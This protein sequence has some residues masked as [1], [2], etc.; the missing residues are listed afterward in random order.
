MKKDDFKHIFTA[1][2]PDPPH[3][4]DWFFAE[5]V[6]DDDCI[7]IG[8]DAKGHA[9]TCLLAQPYTFRYCGAEL[10]SAYISCVATLP[11]SRS[12]G[13]SSALLG[14]AL[15]DLRTKGY[16]LAELIPA[17]DSLYFYYSRFGFATAFYTD[18]LRYTALHSFPK[19]GTEVPPDY[20][21]FHA[22]EM[23][24]PDGVLHSPG[25]Y[26]RILADLAL[27]P[28]H[29][30][31]AARDAEGAQAML[32]ASYNPAEPEGE[33]YVKALLSDGADAAATAL[34]ILRERVGQ[35]PL[36]VNCPPVSDSHA[37]LRPKG[38]VRILDPLPVLRVLAAAN[39]DLKMTIRL[40]DNLLRENMAC[41]GIADGKAKQIE[42]THRV[43]LDVTITTF[44][45][46][47]FSTPS[48]GA[49]FGLPTARPFMSLMLD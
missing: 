15:A 43:D 32:F 37:F 2:F 21:T 42:A 34:A 10:P 36:A 23:R 29:E 41:Y 46:I 7:Y 40:H 28:A 27:E 3:W 13:L 33:V 8:N 4:R 16:A 25:D 44:A 39:P 48:I 1:S 22:L 5:V 18:R 17:H 47:L 6:T 35:R 20:S 49:V 38:M 31:I 30:L 11:Q 26:G 14:D 45:A 24:L 19:T 9:A 12:Q